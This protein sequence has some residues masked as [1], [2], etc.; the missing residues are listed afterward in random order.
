MTTPYLDKFCATFDVSRTPTGRLTTVGAER[1]VVVMTQR[2][3]ALADELELKE[4]IIQEQAA[5]IA[6]LQ[7]TTG[8]FN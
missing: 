5:Q 3:A 1:L 8:I 6:K 7:V 4:R 2:M